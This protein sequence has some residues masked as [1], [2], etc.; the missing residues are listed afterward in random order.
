MKLLVF[1]GTGAATVAGGSQ[2]DIVQVNAGGGT[3]TG[4][5]G[6]DNWI[7]APGSGHAV[8]TDFTAGQDWLT[9]TGLTAA[10]L[11]IQAAT[12]GGVA[13]TSIIYDAAGDSV[14]LAGAAPGPQDILFA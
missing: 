4:G 11:T 9:F 2:T 3:F 8:I 6:G 1:G 5:G 13:G 12:E 10:Q 14:F 7:L